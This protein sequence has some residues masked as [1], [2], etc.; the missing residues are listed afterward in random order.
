MKS[1][2]YVA[3]AGFAAATYDERDMA[4][5]VKAAQTE[6]DFEAGFGVAL[7]APGD[8]W[9]ER[10]WNDAVRNWDDAR[11]RWRHGFA[12]TEHPARP[13]PRYSSADVAALLDEMLGE[14]EALAIADPALAAFCN[15][16][17]QYLCDNFDFHRGE[18]DDTSAP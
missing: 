4:A 1:F 11:A 5:L 18:E 10:R 12:E 13:A 16:W 9:D 3:A 8:M 2:C 17:S 6:P 15:E 7:D 14:L